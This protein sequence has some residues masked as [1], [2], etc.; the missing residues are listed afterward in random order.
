MSV[1]DINQSYFIL[2]STN[3][4]VRG[5]S[6]SIV[7]LLSESNYHY[8]PNALYEILNLH[9]DRTIAEI[10]LIY[11]NKFSNIIEEYFISLV[12]RRIVFPLNFSTE[13]KPQKFIIGHTCDKIIDNAIIEIGEKTIT[14]LKYLINELSE[15]GCEHLMLLSKG[16]NEKNKIYDFLVSFNNTAFRSIDLAVSWDGTEMNSFIESFFLSQ[17]RLFRVFIY[18]ANENSVNFYDKFRLK[19]YILSKD[20]ILNKCE[21]SFQTGFVISKSMYVD[22]ISNNNCLGKKLIVTKDGNVKKCLLSNEVFGD[23]TKNTLSQII[24]KENFWC[25]MNYSKDEIDVCKDCE[26]RYMCIDCRFRRT[27]QDNFSQPVFCTY[28]P[29]I[30]KW[31][32]EDGWISVEQWRA[33]NP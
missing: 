1:I 15:L 31:Q 16:K 22:S 24:S 23:I 27:T 14:N 28:N 11:D 29:Y 9:P 10:K 25:Y 19:Q 7:L 33:E 21:L 17:I 26:F 30:A 32:S 12:K 5:Y 8:I 4:L 18:N 6:R 3:I 2:P 20:N 13:H